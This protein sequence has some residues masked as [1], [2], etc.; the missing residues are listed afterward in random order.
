MGSVPLAS[1]DGHEISGQIYE[2]SLSGIRE[3]CHNLSRWFPPLK[4][5]VLTLR[6]NMW[7][8]LGHGLCR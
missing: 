3:L 7:W 8:R 2:R 4:E 1:R 5:T 6:D